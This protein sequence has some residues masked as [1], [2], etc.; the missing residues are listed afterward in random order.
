M[1]IDVVGPFPDRFE[2]HPA[3]HERPHQLGGVDTLGERVHSGPQGLNCRGHVEPEEPPE[4]AAQRGLEALDRSQA[5]RKAHRD[6]PDHLR[7]AESRPADRRSQRLKHRPEAHLRQRHMQQQRPGVPRLA[8]GD[9]D[10]WDRRGLRR[11]VRDRPGLWRGRP[12][13]QDPPHGLMRNLRPRLQPTRNRA[14]R[15]TGGP[16]R[17]HTG[18][19]SGRHLHRAVRPPRPGGQCGRPVGAVATAQQAHVDRSNPEL[20][21]DLDTREPAR[22]G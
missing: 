18:H 19:Q 3:L 20:L 7:D 12:V 11:R 6:K 5:Q 13:L 10:R 21:R 15:E 16:E 17:P 8:V 22:L 2:C 14:I 9:L 1:A 4:V